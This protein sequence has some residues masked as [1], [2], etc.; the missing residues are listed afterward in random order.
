MPQHYMYI[1]VIKPKTKSRVPSSRSVKVGAIYELNKELCCVQCA[2]IPP[3]TSATRHLLAIQH[4]KSITE[5][6][7]K[8][9]HSSVPSATEVF[10]LR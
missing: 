2:A 6:T 3:A 1:N 7:L 4:L 8:N 5:A 10:Q 9:D